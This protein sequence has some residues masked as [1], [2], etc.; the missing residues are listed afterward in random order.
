VPYVDEPYTG[1]YNHEQIPLAV[2]GFVFS[3]GH[4]E[5]SITNTVML[6]R[7]ADSTATSVGSWVGA[8]HGES[9]FPR[10]GLKLFTK[11]TRVILTSAGSPNA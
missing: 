7:D 11:R 8:L 4:P 5:D 6:G 3:E 10:S 1:H 9:A 2:A